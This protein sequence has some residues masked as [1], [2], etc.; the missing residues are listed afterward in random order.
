MQRKKDTLLARVPG[1]FKGDEYSLQVWSS[2]GFYSC[3]IGSR[4]LFHFPILFSQ[5]GFILGHIL[6]CAGLQQL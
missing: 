4:S 5:M 2:P 1:K 6:P 3:I